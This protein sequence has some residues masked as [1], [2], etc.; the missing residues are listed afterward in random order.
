M[1][2]IGLNGWPPFLVSGWPSRK[3]RAAPRNGIYP[4][5]KEMSRKRNKIHRHMSFSRTD[6][7]TLSG[8]IITRYPD[9]SKTTTPIGRTSEKPDPP[10]ADSVFLRDHRLC[11]GCGVEVLRHAAK[12]AHVKPWADGGKTIKRNL[13]TNCFRCYE[14]D[15]HVERSPRAQKARRKAYRR[16]LR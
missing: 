7:Y 14:S 16:S 12:F 3:N 15:R 5:N 8:P 10:L 9:G 6:S 1:L 4:D 11:R 2:R 13:V